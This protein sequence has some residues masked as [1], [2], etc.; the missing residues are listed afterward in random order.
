M[1]YDKSDIADVYDE[2]RSFSTE[3]L[4]RWLDLL[5]RDGNLTQGSLVVDLGCG[6]GRFTEP[7]ADHFGVRVVGIDPSHK[8]LDVARRKL[9]SE[10]VYFEQASARSL[11]F[12]TG[13]V[14]MVFMSMVFHHFP[15][16]TAVA[17][18]CRRVLRVGGRV[19]VRNTTRECDFPHRHFFPAILPLIESELPTRNQVRCVFASTGF[20]L[21]KHEII[22]QRVAHDWPSFAHKSSL[23]ADSF[24][25]RV[26]DTDFEAGMAALRA[27]AA[28][29]AANEAVAEDLDWYV[30]TR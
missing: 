9:R 29:A 28:D 24:L 21:V 15:N 17:I 13:S 22:K 27:H 20:T 14:D 10:R 8:M 25:A 5:S 7:L 16:A 2:A 26:P 30:F 4:R 18:E 12:A 1:D 11:P 3:G 19:C 6:T 23:R